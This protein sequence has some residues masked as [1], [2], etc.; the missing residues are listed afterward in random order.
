VKGRTHLLY[1]FIGT[2]GPGAVGEQ[3]DCN[4]STELTTWKMT[5]EDE[6]SHED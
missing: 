1:R 3:N 2:I 5:N 6:K 4:V